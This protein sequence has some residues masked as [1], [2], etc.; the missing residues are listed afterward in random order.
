MVINKT[1]NAN[2]EHH[3]FLS[4]VAEEIG[5]YGKTSELCPV[6]KGG[7]TLNRMGSSYVVQCETDNCLKLTSRGI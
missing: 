7:F 1:P 5:V 4:K 2:L 3:V 6:C